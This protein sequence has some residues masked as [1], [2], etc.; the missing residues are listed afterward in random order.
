MGSK[1]KPTNTVTRNV[2]NNTTTSNPYAF[3]KTD[4]NGT[5]S[6][7]QDGTA[8]QSVY[9]FVNKSVDSLL[10]EYLSPSLNSTTNQAKLNNFANTLASQTKNSLEN[11]IINPLSNRNMIRSSQVGDLY[12]NLLNQN[13]AS[14]SEYANKLLSNSQEDTAKMLTN[15]LAYY[16]LGAN[17][18][19][20]MQNNSLKASTNGQM[21]ITNSNS[22]SNSG[23]SYNDLATNVLAMAIGSIL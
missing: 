7:F 12:K 14:V 13:I 6:G 2:L 15:L 19:T 3:S 5:V 4:N 22:G 17:Y 11:D 18:L 16:M 23:N 8:L 20:D 10:N 1:S 21:K 9:N